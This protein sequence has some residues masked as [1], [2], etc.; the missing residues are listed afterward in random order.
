MWKKNVY[1]RNWIA[2][3]W[4]RPS[5]PVAVVSPCTGYRYVGNWQKKQQMFF[6]CAP[7]KVAEVIMEKKSESSIRLMFFFYSKVLY[8]LYL[9]KKNFSL[10]IA[11]L[12]KNQM[13]AK[14]Q[15]WIMLVA[16][17]KNES[18]TFSAMIYDFREFKLRSQKINK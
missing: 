18:K 15:H 6:Y 9:S 14:M 16:F 2:K 7:Q 4:I 13:N 10:Q 17:L 12:V 1:P 5:C 11:S 3:F 8:C